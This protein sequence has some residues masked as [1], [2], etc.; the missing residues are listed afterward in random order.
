MKTITLSVKYID[1][2]ADCLKAHS[3]V[4]L[5]NPTATQNY[6]LQLSGELRIA[7]Q[8]AEAAN[9]NEPREDLKAQADGDGISV[10]YCEGAM[11]FSVS[12][13]GKVIEW[14]PL[15]R[16]AEQYANDLA[17]GVADGETAAAQSCN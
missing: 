16:D 2:I 11:A 6:L 4:V 9:S 17:T 10:D 7:V 3:M 5:K 12:R 14:F 8:N 13:N 15:R 1:K